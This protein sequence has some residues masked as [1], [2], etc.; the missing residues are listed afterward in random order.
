MYL[1]K[2][3]DLKLPVKL[4]VIKCSFKIANRKKNSY[5]QKKRKKNQFDPKNFENTKKIITIL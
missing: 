1:Q 4:S 5:I 2:K 3:D